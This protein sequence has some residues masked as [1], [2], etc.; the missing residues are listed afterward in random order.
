MT[1]RRSWLGRSRR[2]APYQG[3]APRVERRIDVTTAPLCV[4]SLG[5]QWYQ[6]PAPAWFAFAP[7]ENYV[8]TLVR[9]CLLEVAVQVSLLPTPRHDEDQVCHDGSRWLFARFSESSD[10]RAYAHSST[11]DRQQ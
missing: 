4:A 11:I 10:I 7:V 1:V 9:V 6:H 5:S 8:P 3:A 2:R